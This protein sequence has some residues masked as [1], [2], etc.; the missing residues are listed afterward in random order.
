ML[1]RALNWI[2][3]HCPGWVGMAAFG[4]FGVIGLIGLYIRLAIPGIIFIIIMVLL[5]GVH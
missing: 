4:I 2:G 1:D 3:E 5:L